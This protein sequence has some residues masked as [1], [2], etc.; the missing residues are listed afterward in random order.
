M[1]MR[2]DQVSHV[3]TL[4]APKVLHHAFLFLYD[5]FCRPFFNKSMSI[6]PEIHYL[7]NLSTIFN[8]KIVLLK[9]LGCGSDEKCSKAFFPPQPKHSQPK[10]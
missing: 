10:A 6:T 9:A 1:S 3:L 5:S 7:R 2:M 8:Y 4:R